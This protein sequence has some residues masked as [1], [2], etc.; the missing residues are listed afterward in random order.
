MVLNTNRSKYVSSIVAVSFFTASLLISGC[1]SDS[2]S[3]NKTTENNN[4]D[5]NM[6]TITFETPSISYASSDN[7]I[8]L[9]NYKQTGRYA[10]PE[11]DTT[12]VNL[13]AQEASAVTYNKDTDTLFVV[14]DGGTAV[15]QVNK[16]GELIDSMTLGLDASKPQG[17][18]FYDTEGVSYIG[19]GQFALVEERYRQVSRFTY[20]AGSTLG[21]ADVKTVKLAT[22]IGNIGMEGLSY[23]PAT[24]EFIGAKEVDPQGIFITGIDF[25]AGTA[26]NGS[27]TTENPINMFNPAK[28]GLSAFNDVFA[29]SNVLPSTAPDYNQILLLSA[30]DGKLVKLDHTGQIQSTLD[31]GAEAQNEGFTMD[32]DKNIYTVNEV[33]GG[34]GHPQMFVFSP[35]CATPVSGSNICLA[36]NQTVTAGQGNFII[37]NGTGDKHTVSATDSS[38]SYNGQIVTINL[39][40]LDKTSSYTI[41][42][43]QGVVQ[44]QGNNPAPAASGSSL[45]F[46]SAG[47]VDT[48][49]PTLASSIPEDN[50]LNYAG[51]SIILTFDESVIPGNGNIII[52]DNLSNQ[53]IIDINDTTQV[54]FGG[55]SVV[56]TPTSSF[57]LGRSFNVQISSGVITD[58]SGN[59]YGGINNNTTLN[60]ETAK[61]AVPQLL[62]SE[63]NSHA[64]G[65][66]FFE[67]Y[68]FGSSAVNLTGWKYNDS[69]ADFASAIAFPENTTIEA[70]DVL[71]VHVGAETNDEFKTAWGLDANVSVITLSSNAPTDA[72]KLGGGDAAVIFDPNGAVAAAFNYTGTDIGSIP[73]ALRTDGQAVTALHAGPSVST[74]SN[75]DISAVWDGVSTSTPAYRAAQRGDVGLITQSDA[76]SIGTPGAISAQDESKILISEVNSNSEGGD[77]FELYNFGTASVNI[78]GWV[79]DDDSASFNAGA[80][81]PAHIVIPAGERLVVNVKQTTETFK[82]IWNITKAGSYVLLETGSGLSK[83]DAVVLFD[84]K[85]KFITGF[86]YGMSALSVKDVNGTILTTLDPAKDASGNIPTTTAHAG[87]VF[88]GNTNATSAVWDGLSTTDPRYTAAIDGVDGAYTADDNVSIASPGK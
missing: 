7:E 24:S 81:F 39:N 3:S 60:F 9:A 33:G 5:V 59:S 29:L 85:S 41:T 61:P 27:A 21:S 74:E 63:I 48:T 49:P 86:N 51:S 1:G 84:D 26:T 43:A 15:V 17:T 52:D 67:L 57:A 10:L 80:A 75:K 20:S 69:A 42:Y 18:A 25:D 46:N 83:G 6:T 66:D 88:G 23:D 71:I 72:P 56:I 31:V 8:D 4:S 55:K 35:T 45:Q 47:I 77:F 50:N 58:L 53:T 64:N 16:K 37:D 76:S 36:F 87:P 78:S 34:D 65:G 32:S 82:S 79:Y 2:S 28:A 54:R 19:N 62:I 40:N 38:V 12:S 13:L 70:G 14:G 30:P 11:P 68:N 73:T 44:G 22:T